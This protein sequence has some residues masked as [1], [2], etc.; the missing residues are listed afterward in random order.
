MNIVI[1][2]AKLLGYVEAAE[3]VW[4][5]STAIELNDEKSGGVLRL[6]WVTVV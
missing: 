2:V 1:M 3:C 5:W 6:I 4:L